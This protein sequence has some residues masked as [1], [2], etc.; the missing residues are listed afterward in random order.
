MHWLDPLWPKL[1]AGEKLDVAFAVHPQ[2]LGFRRLAF[3]EGHG[4]LEDWAMSLPDG[5]RLHLWHMPDGCWIL[6]RDTIDPAR[7]PLHAALHVATATKLGRTVLLGAAL[8][9]IASA[10]L[11][12]C[13]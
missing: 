1:R 3:A 6:H 12:A 9:G 10:F 2:H 4:Q 13:A 11:F 7:S 5:S 8:V